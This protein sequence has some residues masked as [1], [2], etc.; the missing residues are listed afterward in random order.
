M[1]SFYAVVLILS[2]GLIGAALTLI[3]ARP[4]KEVT[5]P[6]KEVGKEPERPAAIT[7]IEIGGEGA[8]RIGR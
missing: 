3:M 2:A 4:P 7:H 1:N 6:T 5:N 8:V